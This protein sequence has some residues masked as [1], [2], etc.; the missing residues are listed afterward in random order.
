MPF[1]N[2]P[3]IKQHGIAGLVSSMGRI[4]NNADQVNAG[5]HWKLAHNRPFAGDR[6]PIF[7]IKRRMADTNGHIPIRELRF[8][9]ILEFGTV[10]RLVLLNQNAFEHI[11]LLIKLD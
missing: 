4:F 2:P 1:A 11:T 10:A 5:H 9:D 7:V 6:Q 3:T 8:I